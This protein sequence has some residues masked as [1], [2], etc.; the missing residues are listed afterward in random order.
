M[1]QAEHIPAYSNDEL[2]DRIKELSL[3]ELDTPTFEPESMFLD[4]EKAK[5]DIG[6]LASEVLQ[7]IEKEG[8]PV[9]ITEEVQIAEIDPAEDKATIPTINIFNIVCESFDYFKKLSPKDRLIEW[10]M[11]NGDVAK[12]AVAI[13]YANLPQSQWGSEEAEKSVLNLIQMHLGES[14][15]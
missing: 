15:S 2:A 13:T 8:E 7:N 3:G 14:A 11:E 6:Q 10:S 9:G 12:K 5:T 4:E 1:Q